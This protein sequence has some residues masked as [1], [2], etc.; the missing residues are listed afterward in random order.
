MA[1]LGHLGKACLEQ[2]ISVLCV[3][4]R[5]QSFLVIQSPEFHLTPT[6]GK[7][8]QNTKV[9]NAFWRCVYMSAEDYLIN[10]FEIFIFN[11]PHGIVSEYSTSE[12]EH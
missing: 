3:M 5:T 12:S 10:S 8:N 2:S 7:Q 1:K 6:T 11:L 4:K 9:F